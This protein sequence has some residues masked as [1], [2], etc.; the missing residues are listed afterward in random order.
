[1][2]VR[3]DWQ[4]PAAVVFSVVFLTMGALV[5]AGKIPPTVLT[6]LLTWLIPSP[7]QRKD[8]DTPSTALNSAGH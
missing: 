4:W 2:G 7:F 6:A 1:M 3:V 8:G 5:F